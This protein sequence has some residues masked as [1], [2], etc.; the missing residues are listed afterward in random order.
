MTNTAYLG[1]AASK[2]DS[3]RFTT[4]QGLMFDKI[5]KN[6]FEEL[7][8]LISLKRNVLEV[9]CGTGRFTKHFSF[10]F[11]NLIASDASPDMLDLAKKNCEGIKNINF[12]LMQV[13]NISSKNNT[14][15]FVYGI[16]LLNQLAEKN[17][18]QKGIREMIR[19][20]KPGGYVLIEFVNANRLLKRSLNG[21]QL[22]EKE[23]IKWAKTENSIFV[24]SR[25]ACLFSESLLKMI[26]TPFLGIYA[27][28][29]KLFSKIFKKKCARIYILFKKL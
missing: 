14:Y 15:D 10:K 8:N 21:I 27:Y 29:D 26:P 13:D 7:V 25:G 12:K 2:Y 20:T 4:P 17:I 22:K 1:N 6:C 11:D 19:V 28:I 24:S 16:R 23:V 18:A 3:Q 9:G 5:E